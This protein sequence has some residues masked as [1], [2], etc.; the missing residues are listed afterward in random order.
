MEF[1]DYKTWIEKKICNY[2]RTPLNC[3]YNSQRQMYFLACAKI[4]GSS[5]GHDLDDPSSFNHLRFNWYVGDNLMTFQY[6][7]RSSINSI[8]FSTKQIH[9]PKPV[10][11]RNYWKNIMDRI[12]LNDGS[13]NDY[14]PF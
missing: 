11:M 9:G 12:Q 3:G 14:P 10:K 7:Y 1:E 4:R 13:S 6:N 5:P 8:G 2:C